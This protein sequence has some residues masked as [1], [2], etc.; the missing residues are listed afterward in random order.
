MPAAI[1]GLV[2]PVM[3]M[4]AMAASV[5]TVLLNSFAGRLL[6]RGR[7][8]EKGEGI[9]KTVTL[10]VPSMHCESCLAR[11]REALGALPG[12]ESVAGELAEKLVIIRMVDPTLGKEQLCET[13]G[14]IGHRCGDT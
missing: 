6:P 1:T 8:A 14:R 2:H 5:T 9:I 7:V 4:I 13:L 3:A 12:V 11:I 10:T